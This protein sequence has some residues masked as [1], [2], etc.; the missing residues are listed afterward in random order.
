MKLVVKSLVIEWLSLD[1]RLQR[2]I[3]GPPGRGPPGSGGK[4]DLV[5]KSLVIEWPGLDGGLRRPILGGSRGPPPRSG[6]KVDPVV[7]S[8]VIEWP[9]L[10]GGLRRQG[11]RSGEDSTDYSMWRGSDRSVGPSETPRES[12]GSLTGL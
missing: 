8:L 7:K 1:G 10:D 4:V 9:G 12:H 11:G 2:P 5:V 6:G 3:G